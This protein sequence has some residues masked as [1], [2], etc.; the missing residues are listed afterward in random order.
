MLLLRAGHLNDGKGHHNNQMQSNYV[1]TCVVFKKVCRSSSRLR[2]NVWVAH[3]K[4][5]R[6]CR[7]N[8]PNK[9]KEFIC[10]ISMK[11]MK[12][13]AGPRKCNLRGHGRKN[14]TEAIKND[15]KREDA[16]PI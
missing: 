7:S 14:E 16:A 2:G 11:P 1:N 12:S 15:A 5:S 9:D 6:P 3:R 8:Q 10:H 13:N 4:S